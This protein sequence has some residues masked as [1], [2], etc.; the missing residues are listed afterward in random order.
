MASTEAMASSQG[1]GGEAGPVGAA[2]ASTGADVRRRTVAEVT[3]AKQAASNCSV[4]QTGSSGR[5]FQCVTISANVVV[6]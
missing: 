3:A 5:L 6:E 1:G 2:A 4:R